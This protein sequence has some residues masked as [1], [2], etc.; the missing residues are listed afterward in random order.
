MHFLTQG[1]PRW[2]SPEGESIL[3][4]AMPDRLR[5]GI[6]GTGNIARQFADGV[7]KTARRSVI[8]AVGSRT[9]DTAKGFAQPRQIPAAHASYKALLADPN[10]DAVYNS[11][12]N[13]LHHEWTIEALKAGKHVLCEKPFAMTRSE[14]EQMFDVAAK[15]GR[16]LVEAFM[17]RSHPLTHA[18]IDSVRGGE[19]GDVRLIRSS[20]C[21]KT[22]RVDGNVRFDRPLGGGGL[23]DVGC[24]CIN[25]S[26]LFAGEE[27]SQVTASAHFHE[28]GVDDVVVATMKFPSGIV[29]SFTCG[30]SVHADNTAYV[31]GSEGYVEIPVPW[32]PPAEQAPYTIARST[33]PKQDL[34]AGA[35]PRPPRETRLIDAG[36]E[37][38]ALEAD[39]FAAAVLD[40]KPPVLTRADT[41]GNM[42]V[43]DEMRR[44]IGLTF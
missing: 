1:G 5:W 10:V 9:A 28:R 3:P 31:C 19:I 4:A 36:K 11:L 24:Y 29:A 43:L 39:D 26:R 21:Y 2:P 42:A 25:F 20:F 12:P 15:A 40:G 17:Y 38:Y 7:S 27:P 22:S 14:A 33:P 6:L 37:L 32:K 35:N 30:M 44:Q 18:V 16:V 41:L 34:A 8:N 13:N 23:M